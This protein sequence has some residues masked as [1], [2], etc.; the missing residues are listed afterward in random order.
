MATLLG[1]SVINFDLATGI[2]FVCIGVLF[3][4]YLGY[5]LGVAMMAKW[6]GRPLQTGGDRPSGVAIVLAVRNERDRIAD[7]IAELTQ[8]L[9]EATTNGEIIVA[10]NGS[11][12]GTADVARS[13]DHPKL[14]VFQSDASGGKATA[15]S[16]AIEMTTMPVIVLADAR[17]RW[18]PGSIVAMLDAMRDPMVGGVSGQLVL[19]ESPGVMAGVGAYWRYE[20]W[21]RRNESHW[22][23]QIGATG[24]IS[25]VR[26]DC[27]DP[28]PPATI[29][30]DV[31]WPMQVAMRGKRVVA[32]TG[33]IA[34]DQLPEET[35]DEL[36]RKVRT[37]AG[38]FQLVARSPGLLIPWI[39]PVWGRF[40]SHK[41]MRLVCPWAM[42]AIVVGGI[43]MGT[44]IGLAVAI[45]TIGL[46]I[47]GVI[48][49]QTSIGQNQKW[50]AAAGSFVL[51][52]WAAVLAAWYYFT[53][54]S[55][56]LW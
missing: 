3:Y 43:T 40:V 47:A 18:A 12:D 32:V 34:F 49:L 19:E 5:P 56:R 42:M 35:G 50:F 22:W 17:Q 25:A 45:A 9:A 4:T 41:L 26:R 6:M 2:T 24:A 36:R 13:L 14:R 37:L 23:C 38:N 54:R 7:R 33:A 15:I 11:Q 1:E 28:I 44:L 55:D 21:I 29:L 46:I 31:Y 10:V 51:L 27:F 30:D 52:N 8:R 48:G 20:K 16:S 53:G 39:N